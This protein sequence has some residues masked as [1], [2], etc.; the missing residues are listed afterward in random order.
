MRILGIPGSLRVGSTNHALLS[1]IAHV[2]PGYELQMYDGVGGLP[3]FSPDADQHPPARVELL[4]TQIAAAD[5]LIVSAPE[6]AHG[7]PG[8]L[9]NALDWLVSSPV[10][11]DKPTAVW[12]AGAGD[13]TYV[14]PQLIEVL[15]TMSVRMIDAACMVVPRAR[16]A[17]KDGRLLDGELAARIE[18]ALAALS[19]A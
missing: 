6:Y 3:H 1:V 8:S 11:M 17:F 9:K 4:R 18:A 13:A 15:R 12:S 16:Q 5:A 7:I 10:M 19:R 14:H 2:A